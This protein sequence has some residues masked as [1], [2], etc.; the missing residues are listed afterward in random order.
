MI[1]IDKYE[2][3]NNEDGSQIFRID[4]SNKT[5]EL[6]K[7]RIEIFDLLF[8]TVGLHMGLHDIHPGI[9][10]WSAFNSFDKGWTT[11]FSMG[12]IVLFIDD[13]YD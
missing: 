8:R 3:I 7:L 5:T 9:S 10:Y 4:Y 6:L 11:Q 1:S 12:V 13:L 2:I